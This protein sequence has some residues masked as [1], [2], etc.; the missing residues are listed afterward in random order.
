MI[1]DDDT[2]EEVE[3]VADG[4]SDDSEGAE[5]KEEESEIA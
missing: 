2:K 5:T 4:T 3:D 1:L